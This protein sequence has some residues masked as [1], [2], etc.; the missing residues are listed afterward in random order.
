MGSSGT[1]VAPLATLDLALAS[2]AFF[3]FLNFTNPLLVLLSR[4]R[5][6]FGDFIACLCS[7]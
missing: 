3:D 7:T 4:A 5:L 1:L 2:L 6:A